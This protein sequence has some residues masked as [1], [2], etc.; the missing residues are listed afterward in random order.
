MADSR[1]NRLNEKIEQAL[2]EKQKRDA[3]YQVMKRGRDSRKAAV[4]L[5]PEGEGFRK[6]VREIKLR[7]LDAQNELIGRFSENIRKWD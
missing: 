7:C 6:E 3:L 2:A 1:Y 5:L 4:N